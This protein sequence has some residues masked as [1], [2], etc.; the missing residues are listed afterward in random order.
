MNRAEPLG[1]VAAPGS[2]AGGIGADSAGRAGLPAGAVDAAGLERLGELWAAL[3]ARGAVLPS[4]ES[5]R[6]W[7]ASRGARA[8]SARPTG[9]MDPTQPQLM[10]CVGQWSELVGALERTAAGP[11]GYAPLVW[12]FEGDGHRA[13][14]VLW[15][16]SGDASSSER[17]LWALG[18]ER[19]EPIVGEG[20]L[21]RLESLLSE[22]LA[23]NLPSAVWVGGWPTDVRGAMAALSRARALQGKELNERAARIMARWAG[24]GAGWVGGRVASALGG[25]GEPLRVL[26]AVSAH[27][28]YVKHAAGDLCAALEGMGC[29]VRVVAEPDMRTAL[30]SLAYARVLEE[31]DPEV[32]VSIN[33]PRG[34]FAGVLP[35]GLPVVTWVQDAMPHLFP[36]GSEWPAVSGVDFVAG[37]GYEGLVG[38]GGIPESRT[39]RWPVVA[40][41]RKFHGGPVDRG[42]AE[43]MACEVAY[44]S[45]HS[46]S[47]TEFAERFAR[48]NAMDD[49]GARAVGAAARRVIEAA[50][51]PMDRSLASVCIEVSAELAREAWGLT[52]ARERLRLLNCFVYPVAE[53][54][55]RLQT[56]RWA[57]AICRRRGWR[58]RLYGRGWARHADL[59]DLARPAL[60]HGEELRAAYQCAAAHVHASAQSL[61]H[62]RVAECALSGGV[63][64]CRLTLDELMGEFASV[65]QGVRETRGADRC[66]FD[67]PRHVWP[68]ADHPELM[69]LARSMAQ[70]GA[71]RFPAMTRVRANL[72]PSEEGWGW[73]DAVAR[74]G[75]GRL[76][77]LVGDWGDIG[78]CTAEDLEERL[79]ALIESPGR[80][81]GVSEMVAAGVRARMTTE[82]FAREVLGLV[83]RGLG[84]AR[85]GGRGDG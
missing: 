33:H 5:W 18:Q 59:A 58:M 13:V 75:R 10:A 46:E 64:L 68:V 61:L 12:W 66:H 73:I 35:T 14:E 78:F 40:S 7:R 48:E 47:A 17:L 72:E 71:G 28:T 26:V 52:G 4:V 57:A 79:G 81:R 41:G 69:G 62:Q 32:V 49:R 53:K 45:N 15:T 42:L 36:V 39:L 44:A 84:G 9:T 70:V 3:A 2:R 54:A 38:P 56:V 82:V 22:R 67:P 27:S 50:E 60:E 8:A 21:A 85:P 77:P 43:R 76:L 19:L 37:M 11:S 34:R 6:S 30:T 80:R 1:A 83:A 16:A 55:I 25:V 20:A 24:R 51:R 65:A 63:M 23:F 74:S 31:H 29:A